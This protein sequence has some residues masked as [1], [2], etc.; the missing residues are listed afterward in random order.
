M[1]ESGALQ[2]SGSEQARK[3]A[4]LAAESLAGWPDNGHTH[5]LLELTQSLHKR[6][7]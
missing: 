6:M 4:E 5:T 1:R 2:A 7:A 3:Q